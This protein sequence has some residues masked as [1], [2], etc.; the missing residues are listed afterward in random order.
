MMRSPIRPKRPE[1]EVPS[2]PDMLPE[3]IQI[4]TTEDPKTTLDHIREKMERVAGEFAAGKINRPQFNAI[5]AHY[6]E[7]RLIIERLVQR[8]PGNEAWKQV[9]RL[10]RTNFLREHFE[11]VP[12]YFLVFRHNERQPL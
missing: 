8:N 10:G 7:Q 11:A 5:Y 3:T 2:S 4:V 12:L 1:E 6:S 9:A